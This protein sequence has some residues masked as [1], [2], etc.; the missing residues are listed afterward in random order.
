[1][2][3][4]LGNI[5]YFSKYLWSDGWSLEWLPLIP[6]LQV[7]K[8]WYTCIPWV[9]VAP[10]ACFFSMEYSKSEMMDVTLIRYV[11][12]YDKIMGYNS[13]NSNML[14]KILFEQTV[15]DSPSFQPWSHPHVVNCLW[16]ENHMAKN[17][18]WLLGPESGRRSIS[19]MKLR[20]LCI[21]PQRNYFCQQH[22]WAWIPP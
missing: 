7:S 12:L 21:H 10:V 13:G 20:P 18:L 2:L 6:A 8:P 16:R 3:Q 17:C 4:I 5:P 11:T 9:Q 15:N 1:M 22:K 19:S 14:C